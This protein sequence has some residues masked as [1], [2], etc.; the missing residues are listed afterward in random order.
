MPEI[1]YL[2][3]GATEEPPAPDGQR[4]Y[5]PIIKGQS[6]NAPLSDKG[7]LQLYVTA[8]RLKAFFGSQE[9]SVTYACSPLKRTTEGDIILHHIFGDKSQHYRLELRPSL[10]LERDFGSLE[11]LERGQVEPAIQREKKYGSL[12]HALLYAPDFREIAEAV[13]QEGA[14]IKKKL[15]SLTYNPL[16]LEH[17]DP[18]EPFELAAL[19]AY[20]LVIESLHW[21]S[22]NRL[23]P[24]AILLVGLHEIYGAFVINA[25]INLMQ[26]IPYPGINA[27]LTASLNT[28]NPDYFNRR[29]NALEEHR[30]KFNSLQ[31]DLSREFPEYTLH[32]EEIKY[33]DARLHP[34]FFNP[35]FLDNARF[36]RLKFYWPSNCPLAYEIEEINDGKHLAEIGPK[37]GGQQIDKIAEARGWI[38]GAEAEN[39]GDAAAADSLD[40]RL[41]AGQ[42]PPLASLEDSCL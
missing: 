25:M 9:T 32:L 12:D 26:E 28:T 40:K 33:P 19:R 1:I 17:I 11:G 27:T 30:D 4:R 39:L 5:S 16:H 24:N 31:K 8:E 29:V 42:A 38:K 35:F 37:L 36:A 3:H 41:E 2:R 14:S 10:L 18:G 20:R 7:V 21:V 13:N 15:K 34:F 23:N 22:Q 6:T